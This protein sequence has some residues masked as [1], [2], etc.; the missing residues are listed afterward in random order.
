MIYG[1]SIYTPIHLSLLLYNY[2]ACLKPRECNR[3][4]F[5][6]STDQSL[7]SSIPATA[8]IQDLSKRPLSPVL[9][10][11]LGRNK[12]NIAHA[13]R[14]NGIVPDLDLQRALEHL[15]CRSPGT[16]PGWHV[17]VLLAVPVDQ[18]SRHGEVDV[19]G[20]SR[21][22]ERLDD[23]VCAVLAVEILGPVVVGDEVRVPWYTEGIG[24]LVPFAGG[25]SAIDK[26][27]ARV[28][29]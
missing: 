8:H 14:R 29:V 11:R 25:S 26:I 7:V 18:D 20:L 23:L 19:L 12:S 28:E 22:A 15:E 24:S 2:P 13:Q 27:T 6:P 1:R 10:R 5:L 17:V 4:P 9:V 16:L 21:R 3:I